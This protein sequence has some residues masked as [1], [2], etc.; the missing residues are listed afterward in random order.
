MTEWLMSANAKRYD[1]QRAFA[2]QGFIYWRQIR[3]FS[4]GDV[5]YIYCTKPIGKIQ[6]LAV[7][8]EVDIP[9]QKVSSDKKYYANPQQMKE[10]NYIKLVLKCLYKGE[11]MDAADLSRFHFI[12]PQGPQRI[13][14][15]ELQN[16][17]K[18]TF[19]K[20]NNNE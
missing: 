15:S 14:N 10:G 19:A 18:T 16:Y 7:V 11:K 6:Y 3:N 17:I 4:K 9:F 8:E 12:P 20:E 5:V 1:H 13:S 2:E